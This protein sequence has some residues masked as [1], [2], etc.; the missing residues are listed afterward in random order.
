MSI[1]E[2]YQSG[3]S[4]I[5]DFTQ[6]QGIMRFNTVLT[7]TSISIP[8]KTPAADPVL[9]EIIDVVGLAF[10]PECSLPSIYTMAMPRLHFLTH[11]QSLTHPRKHSIVKIPAEYIVDVLPKLPGPISDPVWPKEIQREFSDAQTMLIQGMSPSI[12]ISTCRTVL[13]VSLKKLKGEGQN[14]FSRINDLLEKGII[15]QPIADF[16]HSIRS[17]GADATHDAKG[18]EEDARL[19]IEFLKVFLNIAFSLPA[20]IE[21]RKNPSDQG[22]TPPMVEAEG[23]AQGG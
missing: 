14:I 8:T 9:N 18:D 23:D 17:L 6:L 22:S 15:T 16:A 10:C 1:A 5:V 19:F 13:D 2:I 4:E 20:Q 3:P 21:S 11:R 7:G 12:I